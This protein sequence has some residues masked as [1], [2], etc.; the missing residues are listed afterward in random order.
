MHGYNDNCFVVRQKD[1]EFIKALKNRYLAR[2]DFEVYYYNNSN[3]EDI[4]SKLCDILSYL[5]SDKYRASTISYKI[6]DDSLCV[7]V[8]YCFFV[9]RDIEDSAPMNKM[10]V[11]I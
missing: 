11:T 10:N 9:F 3:L 1:G 7:F 6:N 4:A 8:S 5:D 2:Y